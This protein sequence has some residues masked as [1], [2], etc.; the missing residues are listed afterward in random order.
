M[1]T[2]PMQLL[3]AC[4][5]TGPRLPDAPIDRINNSSVAYRQM[6]RSPL[7][8]QLCIL[9]PQLLYHLFDAIHLHLHRIRAFD[10]VVKTRLHSLSLEQRIVVVVLNIRQPPRLERRLVNGGAT[11]ARAASFEHIQ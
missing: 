1:N 7:S 5:H 11:L 10:D 4:G 8:P 9:L 2:R 3:L 6:F